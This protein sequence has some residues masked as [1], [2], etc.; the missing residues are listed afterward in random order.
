MSDKRLI[1]ANAL[2]KEIEDWHDSL[3]GTMNP[4]DW[5]IQNVLQSVM[6][7]IYE[8][9]DI[10]AVEVVRCRECEYYVKKAESQ[11]WNDNTMRCDHPDLE[12][13]IECYDHW[14]DTPPDGFCYKGKKRD[15]GAER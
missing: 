7:Y 14:L 4:A 13:D 2:M 15:G 6:D 8:A 9:E 3:G 10:D 5:G 12:Y 11:W 1:D